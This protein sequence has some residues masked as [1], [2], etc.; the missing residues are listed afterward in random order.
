MYEVRNSKVDMKNDFSVT[1][2]VTTMIY[3]LIE[4]SHSEIFG[5]SLKKVRIWVFITNS[6]RFLLL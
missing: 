5:F 2:R 1:N 6:A 4:C 3:K